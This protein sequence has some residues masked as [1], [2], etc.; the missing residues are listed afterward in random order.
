ML[1][2]IKDN[3]SSNSSKLERGMNEVRDPLIISILVPVY[4]AENYLKELMEQVHQQTLANWE[5]IIVNDGSTDKSGEICEQLASHDTRIRVIHQSNQGIL[6]ARN[7]GLSLAQG[8]YIGFVDADDYIEA[9]MYE[10]LYK[11]PKQYHCDVV[12]ANVL[13]ET[14]TTTTVSLKFD[15]GKVEIPDQ[16]MDE[17]LKEHFLKFGHAVWHKLF[18]RQLIEQYQLKFH[19]ILSCAKS[20]YYLD[21]PLYHYVIHENFLTK[22]YRAKCNIIAR[23]KQTVQ[24]V[25][26]QYHMHQRRIPIFIDYLT[27]TELLRGLSHTEIGSNSLKQAIKQYSELQNFKSS[28]KRL[29]SSRVFNEYFV[30]EKGSYSKLYQ[31][32]DCLFSWLCL[33]HCYYLAAHLHTIRL[34][35]AERL[36]KEVC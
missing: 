36:I 17:F 14:A 25:Q 5:M 34:K 22:S 6:A 26:Q 24:L 29:V 31:G 12:V 23:C 15:D 1:L 28:M 10:K 32:F 21:E 11:C 30:N 2:S 4:N 19:S 16:Q 9:T 20:I 13:D 35:R 18:R 27:Y 8:D 3:N 7:K 33:C